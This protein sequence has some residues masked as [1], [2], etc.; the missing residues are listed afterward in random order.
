MDDDR[1]DRLTRTLAAGLSRRRLVKIGIGSALGTLLARGPHPHASPVR[2]ADCSNPCSC[3][4]CSCVYYV[5]CRTGLPGGPNDAA[6]YTE[7]VMKSMGYRRVIPRSN[8]IMVW[9]RGAKCANAQSGHMSLVR[10]AVY[11][12][13]TKKWN[14][15]VD[16]ANWN[17]CQVTTGRVLKSSPCADWGNLYGVNFYVPNPT[18]KWISPD[19]WANQNPVTLA[20]HAYPRNWTGAAIDHVNFTANYGGSWRIIST[21]NSPAHDDV[22]QYTWNLAGVPRGWVEIS[23]DVY[24]RSGGHTLAPDGTRK[25]WSNG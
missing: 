24:D 10:R 13:A 21:Q 25:I 3:Q 6:D 1:M 12:T 22:Y 4:D 2:A 5:L 16:D 9:D 20:A 8:A 17:P 14:I 18:G 23:F 11:N 19:W 15:T 7:S